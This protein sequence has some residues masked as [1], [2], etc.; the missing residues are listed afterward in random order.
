MAIK[1]TR[2]VDPQVVFNHIVAADFEKWADLD[3]PAPDSVFRPGEV[4]PLVDSGVP[5]IDAA[6]AAEV[7]L[8][9]GWAAG[10]VRGVDGAGG[11]E[12]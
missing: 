8:G 10:R 9:A 11:G 1:E 2:S 12:C 7:W 4:R 6:M 5:F 3:C